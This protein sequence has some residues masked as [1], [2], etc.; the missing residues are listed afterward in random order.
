MTAPITRNLFDLE[1]MMD[2]ISLVSMRQDH[3]EDAVKEF[4]D[5]KYFLREHKRLE[6]IK[7]K[8]KKAINIYEEENEEG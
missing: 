2:L 8:L 1:E 5:L 6:M 7:N 4:P 3:C